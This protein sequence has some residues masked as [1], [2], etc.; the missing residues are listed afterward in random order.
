MR[1]LHLYIPILILEFTYSSLTPNGYL[2]PLIDY[3]NFL[4][5]FQLIRGI[6]PKAR[7]K[8]GKTKKGNFQKGLLEKQFF[9]RFLMVPP[10]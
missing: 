5:P 6:L 7:E 10:S 9:L 4:I 8:G 1:V 2:F 3:P